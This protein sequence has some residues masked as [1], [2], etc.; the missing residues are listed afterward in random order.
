M[1]IPLTAE[2][3]EKPTKKA[4][5]EHLFKLKKQ[6]AAS[7]NGDEK[8]PSTPT[9]NRIRNGKSAVTKTP[10]SKTPGSKKRKVQQQND[11][12]DS[13]NAM[14]S[15]NE[16]SSLTRDAQHYLKKRLS[17]TTQS[18]LTV[19]TNLANTVKQE[20]IPEPNNTLGRVKTNATTPRSER[21]ASQKASMM[22]KEEAIEIDSLDDFAEQEERA[23]ISRSF[24][25]FEAEETD[26]SSYAGT[27]TDEQMV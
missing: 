16:V 6:N 7:I 2:Q 9:A 3:W 15:P 22:I 25:E 18:G 12:D 27:I 14:M 21:A 4:L 10:G 26:V 17:A 1:E 19:N 8:L 23:R 11:S 5:T 13:D 20:E 24:A